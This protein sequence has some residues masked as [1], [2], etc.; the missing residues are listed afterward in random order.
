M[1]K[2]ESMSLF[3]IYSVCERDLG[4]L[5]LILRRKI[6][7]RAFPIVR[8]SFE[9]VRKHLFGKFRRRNAH[10]VIAEK[11]AA[12]LN[13]SENTLVYLFIPA[14]CPEEVVVG[15]CGECRKGTVNIAHVTVIR[16]K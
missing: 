7:T 14:L 9:R 2:S 11:R 4:G 10:Y 15:S 1:I 12:H 3:S 6:T 8:R 5:S 13:W 16:S